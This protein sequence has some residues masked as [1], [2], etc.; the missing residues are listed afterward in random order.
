MLSNVG[1]TVNPQIPMT[2]ALLAPAADTPAFGVTP[3]PLPQG[4]GGQGFVYEAK[5]QWE[6]DDSFRVLPVT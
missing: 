3:K 4:F 5:P 1:Q 2:E 6:G